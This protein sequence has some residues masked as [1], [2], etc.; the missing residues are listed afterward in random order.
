[1]NTSDNSK[2]KPENVDQLDDLTRFL[3][4]DFDTEDVDLF[5]FT[6]EEDSPLTQL[7]SIVLSLDWEITDNTLQNLA[8]EIYRL[9][10]EEMFQADK[11]SQVYLQGLSKIG[12]YIQSEGAHAHRNAIKLLLTFYYDF[13]KIL[14]SETITGTEITALLKADVRKFKILQYQIAQKHGVE[15]PIPEAEEAKRMGL[16]YTD[17]EALRGLRAVILELDWEV[18]DDGLQRL[19]EQL[20]KL[21][22]KF[23]DDRLIQ[24]LLQGLYSLKSY[25]SEEKGRAHPEAYTLLHTFSE[26]IARLIENGNL[27]EEERQDIIIDQV[28]SL[29]NLK[30]QIASSAAA[31][32]V[33]EEEAITE[34]GEEQ[35]EI[36]PEEAGASEIPPPEEEEELEAVAEG[37][38]GEVD[39]APALADEMEESEIKEE[40]PPE[41]LEARLEF[42]F[43]EEEKAPA[44]PPAEAG[45]EP[46]A[47]PD[48][49]LEPFTEES[50]LAEDADIEPA[51]A[52]DEAE[53][54][55]I[56]EE[57][58]PAELTERLEFF[59]G[60][61]E[62]VAPF[63]AAETPAADTEEVSQVAEEEE[64][65]EEIIPALSG[66][67]EEAGFAAE[68]EEKA[69]E[70]LADK[71][72]DF[73]GEKEEAEETAA[74]APEEEETAGEGYEA[75][76][77]EEAGEEEI[78]PALADETE[79]TEI[80]EEAPPEELTEK[81]EYF[82]GEE[83]AAEEREEEEE[84]LLTPAQAEEAEEF[85]PE[86]ARPMKTEEEYQ[87]AVVQIR[88]H[89]KK[90]EA[91]LR[92]E[93][94]ELKKEIE[95]LRAQLKPE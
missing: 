30:A 45:G 72:E 83:E 75:M 71:L 78:A 95:K 28:N 65:E 11:V 59:F 17:S 22:P 5:E 44:P 68:E 14:S 60:G 76:F 16:V 33:L 74:E 66:S 64:T 39:I 26:G 31:G 13:E 80:I 89:F 77:E 36:E 62:E 63:E 18:S 41:E 15:T 21:K 19:T 3:N 48:E 38:E 55:E 50:L 93:N 1:M 86:A 32:E 47:E 56:E 85:P 24:V 88:T 9:K 82:F 49:E 51:L 2:R 67:P 52:G 12:Q 53:G 61:E 27:G 40:K 79:Q 92:Q 90:L 23:A 8:D 46:L 58:P 57:T 69:P 43:G 7:K 6:S 54:T 42:F 35:L 29:N 37:S 25:I 10:D 4:E 91:A 20:D 84:Y 87:A 73:F 94:A 81:L 70:E 34:V